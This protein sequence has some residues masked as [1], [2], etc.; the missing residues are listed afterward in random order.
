[1]SHKWRYVFENGIEY[2][3][4]IEKHRSDAVFFCYPKPAIPYITT[5]WYKNLGVIFWKAQKGIFAWFSLRKRTQ[6]RFWVFFLFY[7]FDRK[8]GLM[9]MLRMSKKLLQGDLDDGKN[10]LMFLSTPPFKRRS[11]SLYCGGGNRAYNNHLS[12][13]GRWCRRYGSLPL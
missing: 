8:G 10:K 3:W 12:D 9:A 7:I 6:T 2:I 1:M 13:N 5:G 11:T 4:V